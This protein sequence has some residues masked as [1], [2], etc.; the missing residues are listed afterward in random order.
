[1]PQE[2]T[3]RSLD[4]EVSAAPRHLAELRDR[5][6][7]WLTATDVAGELAERLVLAANEAATNAIAHAYRD[8]EPGPVRLT[9]DRDGEVVVVTVA[10]E[11]SWKPARPSE[12]PGGR[13][14]LIMQES[15]DGVR[16]DR[17]TGGTTV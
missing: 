11:G 13:G 5:L 9:A 8:T 17:S 3:Q 6:A 2:P 12:G 16:I 7:R 1:M 10:D 15:M 14:V 4:L